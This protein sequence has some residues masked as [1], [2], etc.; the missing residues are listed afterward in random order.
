MI[1]H[2]VGNVIFLVFD[3]VLRLFPN[4]EQIE[5]LN[6]SSKNELNSMI[7]FYQNVDGHNKR[8]RWNIYRD[9]S[10]IVLCDHKYELAVNS[11]KPSSVFQI[12]QSLQTMNTIK[13]RY[14]SLQS[15]GIVSES[16]T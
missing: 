12:I 9:T 6:S 5:Y 4:S 15:L 10:K 11:I 7:I 8:K 1:T 13:R 16:D 2:W 14:S 3:I